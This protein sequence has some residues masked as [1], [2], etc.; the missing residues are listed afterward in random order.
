MKKTRLIEVL[1]S[2]EKKELREFKKWLHSPVHNQREDVRQLY[3]YLIDGK[4]LAK[5]HL[6]HKEKVF[7]FLY[8]DEVYDDAKMRQVSYFF[9]KEMESYLV[10]ASSRA[11]ELE[12]KIRLARIYNERELKREFES[13]LTGLDKL[14]DNAQYIDSTYHRFNYQ[15]NLEESRHLATQKRQIA[16]EKMQ[17]VSQKLDTYFLSEKLQTSL[18]MLTAQSIY[19]T[20]FDFGILEDILKYIEENELYELPS[21]GVYYFTFRS[22]EFKD[23]EGYYWKLKDLLMSNLDTFRVQKL[24]EFFVNLI[25]YCVG[26]SNVGKKEFNRELFELYKTGIDK[27][28]ITHGGRISNGMFINIINNGSVLREFNWVENFI[29]NF[30]SDIAVDERSGIVNL[31]LGILNFERKQYSEAKSFLE[32]SN[33]KNILLNL[34]TRNFLLRTYYKLNKDTELDLLIESMGKYLMRK[35]IVGYARDI[36]KNI[37]SLMK[38]LVNLNIY[39][40]DERK[41]FK[42][43]VA[44]INP[45]TN[46]M[47][48]WFLE[49]VQ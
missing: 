7:T 33:H 16:F 26:K 48:E 25:N 22:L 4:R 23:E 34:L 6:I 46:S 18:D 10:F 13:N 2:F 49:Q 42:D 11:D 17:E 41:K 31:G 3:A 12:Y 37:L 40:S 1:R 20:E 8:P 24:K 28:I 35:E 43:Q 32:E 47:R 36:Y 39:D 15:K 21:I 45:M 30:Q 5:D 9:M 19:K 27:N 14:L 29:E 44:E 38:K